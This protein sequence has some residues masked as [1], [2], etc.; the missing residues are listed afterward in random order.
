MGPK[1]VMLLMGLTK[2]QWKA[3]VLVRSWSF[4]GTVPKG[5]CSFP[6]RDWTGFF[7]F[8]TSCCIYLGCCIAS[9]V[10]VNLLH[11][12]CS[13][14]S[15]LVALRSR[16]SL[17]IIKARKETAHNIPAFC[18]GPNRPAVVFRSKRKSFLPSLQNHR[19]RKQV[20]QLSFLPQRR[21]T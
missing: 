5:Y 18:E 1:C 11:E 3:S 13:D 20:L 14:S 19:S 10:N 21:H 9:L 16:T 17:N 2:L 6:I 8:A 4:L 12:K 15:F 7:T